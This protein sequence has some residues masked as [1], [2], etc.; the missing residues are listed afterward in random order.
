MVKSTGIHF[1][2]LPAGTWAHCLSVKVLFFAFRNIGHPKA[3]GEGRKLGWVGCFVAS[4]PRQR[5]ECEVPCYLNISNAG[6]RDNL[7]VMGGGGTLS[8]RPNTTTR[9][10]KKSPHIL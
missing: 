9:P 3:K 7:H 5:W 8:R 1:H 10:L 6:P 4:E 2:L